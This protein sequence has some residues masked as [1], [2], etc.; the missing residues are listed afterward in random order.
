MTSAMTPGLLWWLS[1]NSLVNVCGG[2]S[3]G[4]KYSFD[5]ACPRCGTGAVRLGALILPSFKPP[6]R[7]VF[8]TLDRE[9]LVTEDVAAELRTAGLRCLGPVIGKKDGKPLPVAELVPEGAL[10]P[11]SE[12]TTGYE[13][14]RLDPP[15]PACNRDAYFG[16]PK[17][18]LRLCYRNLDPSL[19]EKDVLSTYERFGLSALRSPFED[20]VFASPLYVVSARV[21]EALKQAKASGFEVE[22]V[23]VE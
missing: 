17:V 1:V 23:L 6:K 18:T 21:V 11:F 7:S 22:P 12:G 8:Q 2:P 13:R 20:S 4:N 15:C 19:L 10:P 9:V 5:T 3:Q 14:S 16:V